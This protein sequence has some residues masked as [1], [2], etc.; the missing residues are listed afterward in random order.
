MT[1]EERATAADYVRGRS[2]GWAAAI[3]RLLGELEAT[4]VELARLTAELQRVQADAATMRGLVEQV[5]GWFPKG[6]SFDWK[7]RADAAVEAA[8]KECGRD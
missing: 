4:D 6:P 2:E 1:T 3:R 8:R 7:K 5:R